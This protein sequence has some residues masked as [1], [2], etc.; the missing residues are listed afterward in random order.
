MPSLGQVVKE[1]RTQRGWTQDVLADKALVSRK[2]ISNIERGTADIS[3][4]VLKKIAVALELRTV[5]IDDVTI[6]VGEGSQ[7]L[8]TVDASI[9]AAI[10]RL[11]AARSLINRGSR[12]RREPK[13]EPSDGGVLEHF[14]PRGK[15]ATDLPF[16]VPNL[17][18]DLAEFPVRGYVAAGRP[19]DEETHDEVVLLPRAFVGENEY[20]LRARGESMIEWGIQDGDYVIVERR[21]IAATGE[22]VIA[23]YNEGIT[24]KQWFYKRGRRMLVAGNPESESYELKESDVVEIKGVVTGVWKSTRQIVGSKRVPVERRRDRRT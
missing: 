4:S 23:W 13:A 21:S 9:A 19:I 14:V 18:S 17:R 3:V 6:G 15:S 12:A 7:A 8:E 11:T 24:V 1:A 5:P 10:E 2:H 20:I 22:L 16:D